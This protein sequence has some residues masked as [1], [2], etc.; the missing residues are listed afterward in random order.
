[1]YGLSKGVGGGRRGR[2]HW[3]MIVFLGRLA[4]LTLVSGIEG[5]TRGAMEADHTCLF[6][7]PPLSP[8]HLVLLALAKWDNRAFP[9]WQ[10]PPPSFAL[11]PHCQEQLP[12]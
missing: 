8:A 3:T 2:L 6:Y 5:T 12:C 1:M 4:S 11:W 9:L 7:T 10:E